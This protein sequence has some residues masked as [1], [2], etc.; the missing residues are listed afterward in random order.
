MSF[1]ISSYVRKNFQWLITNKDEYPELSSEGLKRFIP[2]GYDSELGWIRKPLTSHEEKG[3]FGITKWNIDAKGSRNNPGYENLKTMIS[4]YGDSFTFCRQ[5][6]D[7][8]TWEHY[9]SVKTKSN[10]QNFGVGNYGIDQALLRLKREIQKNPTK[11]VIMAVVPDTISRILSMWKHYYEYGNT[12]AFK[13][14]F[15]LKNKKISLINNVIDDEIKFYEYKKELEKIKKNDYFY[16]NK[17]QKEKIQFP[18]TFTILKN[19]KRN[20]PIIYWVIKIEFLKRLGKDT[21]K[22]EWN[23]MNIIMK[24]NLKWRIKLYKDPSATELLFKIIDEFA[25]FSNKN[26]IS[27]IFLFIPQKDDLVFIKN[28]HHYFEDFE[29]SLQGIPN[30]QVIDV[31]KKI[32]LEENLDNL[33]SDD[34]TYGGHLSKFGNEKIAEIIF[35][36]IKNI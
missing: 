31:T 36:E 33:Y 28:Y 5:V 11:I 4:C 3:R 20:I 2:N 23:P 29:K 13:P 1:V 7:D 32:L 21:S 15:I 27:P 8:E 24:I 6:N 34:N 10:V 18:Y 14:R 26:N 12:F 25:S 22:I 9:L 16:T 19:L 35:Q 17:F 30:L